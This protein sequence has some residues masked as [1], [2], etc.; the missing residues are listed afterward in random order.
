VPGFL[1]LLPYLDSTVP[2]FLTLLP[3]LDST[4]LLIYLLAFPTVYYFS[5]TMAPELLAGQYNSKADVWSVGV[6]A[7]MLLSSSMPFFGATRYQVMKRICKAKVK[8]TAKRWAN[9]SKYG[10]GFVRHLLEAD[11]QTRPSADR[12]LR[13]TKSWLQRLMQDDDNNQPIIQDSSTTSNRKQ[14]QRWKRY[15]GGS[16]GDS[17]NSEEEL[18]MMDKIQASSQAFSQYTT[19]KK[20]GLM[21]IAFKSTASEIGWLRTTFSRFDLLQNGEISFDEFSQALLEVYDYTP[22]ELETLFRGMDIDGTDSVHYTEFLAATMEAHGSIDEDRVA[23]AFDRIGTCF[24]CFTVPA[25]RSIC[26]LPDFVCL[27]FSI[28]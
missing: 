8:M 13:Y 12:A 4:N 5:Y 22:Q 20:L 27:S 6:I 15:G 11:P 17:S 16:S 26:S 24:Q 7:F 18:E 10:Q 23:D 14:Q 28:S 21:V 3:Y 25:Q 2:G 19:L 9:V 1:T